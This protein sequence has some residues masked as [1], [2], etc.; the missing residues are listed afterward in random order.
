MTTDQFI[1]RHIGPR[2]HE[3]D[4]MLEKVGSRTME[5]FISSV[6]PASIR[7]KEPLNLA[8]ALTEQEYANHIREIG[9]KNKKF[10]SLIGMGYYGT[11]MPP[12]IKRNIL[13][14]PSWYTSYTPYQAEISQ[15]RLEALLNFQTMVMELTAMPI[16]NASL[17][18]EGTAAAEAMIM[19]FNARSRDLVK[20]DADVLWIDGN[21]FPQTLEVIRTRALPLGIRVVV[22]NILN[23]RLHDKVFGVIAQYPAGDGKTLNFKP[24]VTRIHE[25]G[26]LFTAISDL[27]SLVLLSPPGEWGADIVAGTTQRFGIPMGFGGPHAAYFATREEL[28]RNM[29]GRIIGISV[30]IHGNKALRMALQTREQ[31]I[32][33][34]KA[35]SNICTAQALLASMAGMYVAYHG[36]D[37]LLEIAGKIHRAAHTLELE[38]QQYGYVQENKDYF[39]TLRFVLPEKVSLKHFQK[40]ALKNE[41]NFRYFDDGTI[42]LSTD[43]LTDV[44]EVNRILSVFTEAAGKE[45]LPVGDLVDSAGFGPDFA[46]STNFLV[47][48]CFNKYQSETEMMRYIKKLE[49]RDISLTHS[50]IPLGSCTMKLNPANAMFAMSWDEFAG[51]HPFVPQDQAAGYLQLIHELEMA[52]CEITGFPAISFQP[53]SGASGE[54]AGLMVINR[55]HQSR[56]DAQRN[57]VLIPASAHGTNPASA[58]MA[59]GKVIVVRCDEN[60]N[61]DLDDLRAKA[62]EHAA[63]LGAYMITYPSTHGVFETEVKEM[64]SIIHANGGQVYMDGANMNAQVGLTKPALIGADVCHLN[65][66]KTFGIPH[67]GGGPGVGP[68]GVAKHL[69]DFLP[70]H[71]VIPVGGSMGGVISSA[72][73]GS[74]LVLTIS[75]AYVQMLGS[76]GLTMATKMA[77]LNANYLVALLKGHYSVLFTGANGRVAHECILD[78]QDFKARTGIETSDIARRLMDYGFHAPTLSFPV[79]ETLMVEP[80]ESESKQELDRFAESLISILFEITDV[81]MGITDADNN[82]LKNAPHTA[83][84]IGDDTWSHPYGRQKAAFPLPWVGENKF[85]PYVGKI[86]NA[87]GDRNLVC[88]CKGLDEY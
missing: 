66:H 23:T 68:I 24:T 19:M 14:N 49:R 45:L 57:V 67:G 70:S 44:A 74:A 12:V 85:W 8:P 2:P 43:E 10:R 42:G 53:N 29:P 88:S 31:H 59:G 21:I 76:E 69:V 4:E 28:K 37:G 80:T 18:D 51:V 40:V 36:P 84:H 17:L 25:L 77:I 61:V 3:I 65:L 47:E 52:L 54:Y 62:E 1:Y 33:R 46:R 9:Q 81:E 71:P 5:E 13:E 50:M 60:G 63:N 72:P 35:T 26:G 83:W 20:R 56:G 64:A 6:V 30:D 78:C 73:Y 41:I 82:V 48:P 38:L 58:V 7:M 75:H 86:D 55:Y 22:C 27:Y 16:A 34:E 39:D 79:H 87:F 15:G 32:K 11:V